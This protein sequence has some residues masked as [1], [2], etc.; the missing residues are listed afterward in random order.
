MFGYGKPSLRV[1]FNMYVE[2]SAPDGI[3]WATAQHWCAF[4]LDVN[5]L[6]HLTLVRGVM[7]QHRCAFALEVYDLPHLTL[8]RGVK[9][10]HWTAF[11]L[12]VNG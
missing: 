7:A 3:A 5:D 9:A 8:V 10:Q 6:P 2:L 1:F 12:G 4:A 11:T